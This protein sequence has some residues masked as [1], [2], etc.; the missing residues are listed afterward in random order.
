[1]FKLAEAAAARGNFKPVSSYRLGTGHLRF[2][3]TRLGYC[4]ARFYELVAEMQ[5]RNYVTNFT[6]P[7]K[8]QV[9]K[10]WREVWVPDAAA[11]ALNRQ[12]L[13]ERGWLSDAV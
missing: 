12:R 1:V 11:I 7:P 8:V 5:R 9:P 6:K 13:I 10:S 3:Y 2:F 4:V